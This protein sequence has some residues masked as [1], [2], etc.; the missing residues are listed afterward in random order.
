MLKGQGPGL[1]NVLWVNTHT[2]FFFLLERWVELYR[3]AS[4]ARVNRATVMFGRGCLPWFAMAAMFGWVCA[5]VVALCG[6]L[7]ALPSKT[8]TNCYGFFQLW[9]RDVSEGEPH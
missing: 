4:R 2:L 5:G 6:W 8:P 1:V 3:R 7:R 9:A